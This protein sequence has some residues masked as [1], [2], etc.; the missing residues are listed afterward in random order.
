MHWPMVLLTGR[1]A[2]VSLLALC[3]L[4]HPRLALIQL[5][6]PFA[7]LIMAHLRPLA[8][9]QDGLDSDQ[10][11]E[12]LTVC[13]SRPCQDARRL[14][15]LQQAFVLGIG[16]HPKGLGTFLGRARDGRIGAGG[17]DAVERIDVSLVP[18]S[19]GVDDGEVWVGE[20]APERVAA[21][22]KTERIDDGVPLRGIADWVRA[23]VDLELVY[24]LRHL[25]C[26]RAVVGFVKSD[27]FFFFFF[28]LSLF[29]FS[30]PVCCAKKKGLR[31]Y[32]LK[33]LHRETRLVYH[34]MSMKFYLLYGIWPGIEEAVL[35]L[36]EGNPFT[37][38]RRKIGSN[39]LGSRIIRW[40]NHGDIT[41]QYL[42]IKETRQIIMPVPLKPSHV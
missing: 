24:R 1:V 11:D 40:G 26:C 12:A 37:P 19:A 36:Y 17:E 28:S 30:L 3:A 5:L 15:E 39:W 32:A 13:L 22:E 35:V 18:K 27:A 33:M 16:L 4:L 41:R 31:G 29:F 42:G 9:H 25:G 21:Q 34:Y 38:H 23:V 20:I 6:P 2:V 7:I 8:L 10:L 14:E